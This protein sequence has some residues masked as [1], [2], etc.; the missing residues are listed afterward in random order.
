MNNT[1]SLALSKWVNL[2]C[3]TGKWDGGWPIFEIRLKKL[4]NPLLW[5]ISGITLLIKKLYENI[6]IK[7]T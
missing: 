5:Q 2:L 1:F 4:I 7:C 6:G 3:P